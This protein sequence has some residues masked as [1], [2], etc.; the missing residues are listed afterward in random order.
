MIRS[1]RLLTASRLMEKKEGKKSHLNAGKKRLLPNQQ[2]QLAAAEEFFVGRGKKLCITK[3]SY[4]LT[5]ERTKNVLNK[6]KRIENP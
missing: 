4:C 2:W 6:L 5:D 3:M 1:I